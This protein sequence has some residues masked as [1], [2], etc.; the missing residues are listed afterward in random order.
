MVGK[1]KTYLTLIMLNIQ[2]PHAILIITIY[3]NLVLLDH[4]ILPYSLWIDRSTQCVKCCPYESINQQKYYLF[5][6]KD[7]LQSTFTEA[8]HQILYMSA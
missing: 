6:L 7:I 4:F 2:L 8:M 5:K 3:S 1:W